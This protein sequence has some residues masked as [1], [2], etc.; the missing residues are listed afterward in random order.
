MSENVIPIHGCGEDGIL[1]T[2]LLFT[3]IPVKCQSVSLEKLRSWLNH[4]CNCKRLRIPNSVKK[5]KRI[6]RARS[7]SV[8]LTTAFP[9]RSCFSKTWPAPGVGTVLS[10]D[11]GL[12]LR[13]GLPQAPCCSHPHVGTP[14]P[15]LPRLPPA[16]VDLGTG[17]PQ[18]P[19]HPS[20]PAGGSSRHEAPGQD[21]LHRPEKVTLIVLRPV[22]SRSSHLEVKMPVPLSSQ[23]S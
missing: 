5:E 4:T 23:H 12:G 22:K 11:P 6:W 7:S 3:G 9:S 20:P 18:S 19:P 13:W 1:A 16:P 14:A 2:D 21:G 17:V 15:Q 10:R 8:K